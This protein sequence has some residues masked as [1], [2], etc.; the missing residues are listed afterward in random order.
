MSAADV[1]T[2]LL[3]DDHEVVRDGLRLALGRGGDV[4]IVG[5]AGDAMAAVELAS[6]RRPDVVMMDLHLG[7]VDGLEATRL[8]RAA[9]P[10]CRVVIFTAHPGPQLVE[11]GRKAGASGFLLKE[12]D[13]ATIAR[14]VRRVAAG[15]EVVDPQLAVHLVS[16]TPEAALSA[17]EREILQL[18]AD[19]HSNGTVAERLFIS[20]ETV[21]SHVKNVLAKLEAHTR[22]EAVA[23]ALRAAVIA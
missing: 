22:T 18:L 2:C 3:A 13:A 17:R 15:Q 1:I 23:I 11:Q 4:R 8:I 10:A 19:G 9:N 20:Q 5:E 7:G 21:K 12:A 14:T 16:A 6:R